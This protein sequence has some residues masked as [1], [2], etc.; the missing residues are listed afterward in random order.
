MTKILLCNDPAKLRA[1]LAEYERTV[2]V[3]AEYGD[4]VVDGTE[5][6]YAHH[7]KRSANPAPCLLA[8]GVPSPRWGEK[9]G[10][11][12]AIGLSHIDLDA[13]GGTLA[14]L[15]Q[16]P[17]NDDFWK[18]AAFVDVNGPHKLAAAGALPEIVAKLYAY[19]A[20]VDGRKTYAP[21]DGSVADVTEIIEETRK[22]LAALLFEDTEEFDQLIARG[23]E[24]RLEGEKLN[25]DSFVELVGNVAVRVS[26]AFVNHIYTTPNGQVSKGVVALNPTHGGITMSI[27]D[28][29]PG[30]I[31]NCG[32]LVK[33]LWGDLAGG[34]AGIAGSPRNQR[35]NLKELLR[36]ARAL[37]TLLWGGQPAGE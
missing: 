5:A 2:T 33:Y 31:I 8:N 21:R 10:R 7:G 19:W 3:E 35:Q 30:S 26:P 23:E 1:A 22:L 20:W 9:V 16:K 18:L 11:V 4:E 32:R 37:D 36:A 14:V 34:H 12:D 27:A 17:E 13:V 25:A 29:I 6:T 28:P 15:D 24:F